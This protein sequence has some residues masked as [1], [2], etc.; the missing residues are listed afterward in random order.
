[1]AD[2]STLEEGIHA[3]KSGVDLIGI[4]MS[5]Y[6]EYSAKL[7]GPDYNLVEAL[8]KTLPIPVIA[9]GRI[10]EPYQAAAMFEKGAYA[11]VVGGAITDL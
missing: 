1:M 2:I 6:T 8:A 11:V 10:H 4:T 9:E 5:G 3:Y 7:E